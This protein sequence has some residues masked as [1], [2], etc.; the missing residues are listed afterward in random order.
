MKS[1]PGIFNSERC[2]SKFYGF[3]LM[4]GNPQSIAKVSKCSGH[5]G[6]VIDICCIYY[7]LYKTK[8]SLVLF[9]LL[10]VWDPLC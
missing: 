7:A 9:Y 2:R 6:S 1:D 10:I 8:E 3:Y 5:P 4:K